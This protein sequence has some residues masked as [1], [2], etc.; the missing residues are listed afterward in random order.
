MHTSIDTAILSFYA[1]KVLLNMDFVVE[2]SLSSK[3]TIIQQYRLEDGWCY[4][5][6]PLIQDVDDDIN[7]KGCKYKIIHTFL[8]NRL[9][10]FK[11]SFFSKIYLLFHFQ[12]QILNGNIEPL[13]TPI[14]IVR[15]LIMLVYIYWGHVFF[16]ITAQIQNEISPHEKKKIQTNESRILKV[17]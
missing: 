16:H 7:K 17:Q 9:R 11:M 15:L 13:W 10:K 5:L 8:G 2:H 4:I 1:K 12:F 14:G 3:T 6:C